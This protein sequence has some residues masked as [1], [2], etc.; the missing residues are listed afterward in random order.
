METPESVRASLQTGEWV[1]SIDFKD[2]SFHIP[3]NP[4]TRKYLCVTSKVNPTN[5][6]VSEVSEKSLEDARILE[7]V[8]RIPAS[9]YPHLK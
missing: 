3:I 5:S 8:I 7:K 2:A 6:K 4:L 9:L 1:M